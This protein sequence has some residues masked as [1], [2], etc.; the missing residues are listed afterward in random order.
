MCPK[1]RIA[2]YDIAKGIAILA[3]LFA[4]TPGVPDH[5]YRLCFSFHLPVF[6]FIAGY[7]SHSDERPGA[8][9]L[10][11]QARANLVPYALTCVFVIVLAALRSALAHPAEL[12]PTLRT[13]AVASLFGAG[14]WY[15]PLPPGVVP[16]GAIWFLLAL[17]WA[18]VLMAAFN[19]L[20]RPARPFVVAACVAIG[21]LTRDHFW[22]PWSIQSGLVAVLFV[23]E[24]QLARRYNLVE[25]LRPLAWLAIA[26]AW[27]VFA[28]FGG[29]LYLACNIFE[30]G[31]LVDLAGGTLG[32]LAL[33]GMARGIERL[34]PVL[35]R[36]LSALGRITLPILCMHLVELDLAPLAHPAVVS[37]LDFLPGPSWVA[38]FVLRLD[39]VAVLCALLYL[40]PRPLSG[41]FYASRRA[42]PRST[43]PPALVH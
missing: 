39:L 19:L 43:E 8:P 12:L 9:F 37:F 33:I 22:L 5:L 4:H 27:L 32:S 24:G 14:S 25:R 42:V 40:L 11:K 21:L 31:P 28:W 26:A 3:V 2:C 23:Y 15:V 35:V 41:V 16:I 18:H 6:F 36:P 1:Q 7:F 20:P 13:W 38:E 17:F 10:R 30:D 29:R 34:A